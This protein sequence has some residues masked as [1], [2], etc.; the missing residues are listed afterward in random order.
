MKWQYA[1]DTAMT[2]VGTLIMIVAILMV[3]GFMVVGAITVFH[4]V[5]RGMQ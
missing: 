5:F 2:V 1:L 3:L 4:I